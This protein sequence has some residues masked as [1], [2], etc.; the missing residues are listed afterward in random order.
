VLLSVACVWV[1]EGNFCCFLLL[2]VFCWCQL[3]TRRIE[4]LCLIF[5]VRRS[6][7]D[8]AARASICTA[9]FRFCSICCVRS[10][11]ARSGPDPRTSTELPGTLF[12]LLLSPSTRDISLVH[13]PARDQFD[14]H[15][16]SC[17]STG[18]GQLSVRA[19]R[20]YTLCFLSVLQKAVILVQ[21]FV[22]FCVNRCRNSS[23]S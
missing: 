23:R 19:R 1:R 2:P 21:I 17:A 6:F 15:P 14:D 11:P 4:L 7:S 12:S 10:A 22:G 13:R 5:S 3:P 20:I 16:G 9:Q 8:T 18:A